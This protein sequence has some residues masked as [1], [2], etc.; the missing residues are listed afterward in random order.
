MD[1]TAGKYTSLCA[2]SSNGDGLGLGGPV[3]LDG[4]CRLAFTHLN[5][6]SVL[7]TSVSVE[8]PLGGSLWL[9]WWS[10]KHP[11]PPY[12]YTRF[13][14]SEAQ[15]LS[16]IPKKRCEGRYNERPS[17]TMVSSSE[18][19]QRHSITIYWSPLNTYVT[20]HRFGFSVALR[21]SFT[22]NVSQCFE[23]TLMELGWNLHLRFS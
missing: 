17:F 22:P 8:V 23:G 3:I 11:E 12:W 16:G 18:L 1:L 19:H 2:A 20:Q 5:Y 9:S 4:K 6:V 14:T 15:L 7:R 10:P 21:G 13:P